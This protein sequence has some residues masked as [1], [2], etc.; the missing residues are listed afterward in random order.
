MESYAQYL[1]KFLDAYK[2]E[3]IDVIALT[4]QNEPLQN[5][6]TYPTALFPPNLE[7]DLIR[8]HLGP[9]LQNSSTKI[10]CFDHNYRDLF[11][12][13]TVLADVKASKYIQGTAFHNYG[14]KDDAMSELHQL[15]PSKDIYF[16]EGSEFGVRGALGIIGILRN[17]AKTYNAWVTILDSNLQPNAG[18]YCNDF[19][20]K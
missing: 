20:N 3:G 16:S 19:N 7:T 17:W 18:K 9:L 13:K 10:W 8:D 12:P 15:H 5:E 1:L 6:N 2:Q 4:P 14:G 11:Y